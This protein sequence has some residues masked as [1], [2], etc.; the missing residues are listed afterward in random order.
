MP[1]ALLRAGGKFGTAPHPNIS[2]LLFE[3]L[4]CPA[5]DRRHRPALPRRPCDGERGDRVAIGSGPARP[6][7]GPRLD[8]ARTRAVP[9]QHARASPR[10]NRPR[11]TQPP[12]FQAR[13][14][15]ANDLVHGLRRQSLALC[16]AGSLTRRCRPVELSVGGE[17][18]QVVGLV[19][20]WRRGG[21]P[22]AAPSRDARVGR[23][24]ETGLASS[25]GA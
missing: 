5:A 23:G 18:V 24:D 16:R 7:S 11:V 19:P 8:S 25:S 9:M 6:H 1:P 13:A 10:R 12:S 2:N 21:R 15:V 17:A 3:R 4:P 20:G 22:Q 14:G